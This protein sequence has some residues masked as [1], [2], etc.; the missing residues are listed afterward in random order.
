M[1]PPVISDLTGD[2]LMVIDLTHI[3]SDDNN[4][5]DDDENSDD[6]HLNN[7]DSSK[8]MACACKTW[9][10]IVNYDAPIPVFTR[11]SN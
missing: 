3:D 1:N 10:F 9:G 5:N 2:D 6:N 7:D 11:V 4:D 8:N